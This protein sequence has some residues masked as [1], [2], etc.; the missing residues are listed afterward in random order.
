M[1]RRYVSLLCFIHP[2]NQFQKPPL[3]KSFNSLR[4]LIPNLRNPWLSIHNATAYNQQ[5]KRKLPR[6]DFPADFPVRVSIRVYNQSDPGHDLNDLMPHLHL[7]DLCP[8][9]PCQYVC[10][11]AA[12]YHSEYCLPRF[13]ISVCHQYPAFYYETGPCL[14]T[15]SPNLLLCKP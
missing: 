10:E 4:N 12:T 7:P 3:I 15:A 14:I 8:F 1:D 6:L 9:Q 11:Y 13:L 2:L 5:Q